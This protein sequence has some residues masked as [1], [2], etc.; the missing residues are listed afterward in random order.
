[1]IDEYKLLENEDIDPD[2][3][4]KMRYRDF[5]GLVRTYNALNSK[6]RTCKKLLGALLFGYLIIFLIQ[7]TQM[8]L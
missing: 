4:V 8:I 5:K 6:Y 2:T 3:L 1:M 7:I